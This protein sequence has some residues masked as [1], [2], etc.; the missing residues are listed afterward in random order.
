MKRFMSELG[1]T[2]ALTEYEGTNV[3][4]GNEQIVVIFEKVEK[5][6]LLCHYIPH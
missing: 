5:G 4:C 1:I 2:K 6:Q 3:C